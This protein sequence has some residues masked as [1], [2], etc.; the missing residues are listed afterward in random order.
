[1][2]RRTIE[3]GSGM[4]IPPVGVA[5][6]SS[7]LRPSRV[8]FARIGSLESGSTHVETTDEGIAGGFSFVRRTSESAV[9]FSITAF[10]KSNGLANA[11]KV[12]T[13][14][15]SGRAFE[16]RMRSADTDP[17]K[18]PNRRTP[19]RKIKPPE[20]REIDIDRENSGDDRPFG[21]T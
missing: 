11:G 17:A 10:D 20:R 6:L 9:C 15:A 18:S 19:D 2:S 7:N 4:G 3:A 1:M 8:D 21:W 12:P 13:G 16:G 5:E 14:S